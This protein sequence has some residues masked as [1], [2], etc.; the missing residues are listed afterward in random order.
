MPSNPDDGI[1]DY[2]PIPPTTTRATST[3]PTMKIHQRQEQQRCDRSYHHNTQQ[4]HISQQHQQTTSKT[5]TAVTPTTT[6]TQRTAL[7]TTTTTATT[8]TTLA[9]GVLLEDDIETCAISLYLENEPCGVFD[10]EL[11]AAFPSY[12][13]GSLRVRGLTRGSSKEL[14]RNMK[15]KQILLLAPVVSYQ[16]G[17]RTS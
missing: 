9:Q 8:I 16:P 3:T 11:D 13:R 12:E 4:H 5:A 6:V 10:F 15:G 2:L 17:C 1:P 7:T 14:P